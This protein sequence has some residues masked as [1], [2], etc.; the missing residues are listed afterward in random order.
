[1]IFMINPSTTAKVTINKLDTLLTA[2]YDANSKNIV[3]VVKKNAKGNPVSGVRI[4][5]TLDGVKYVTTDANGQTL[6]S[7][8]DFGW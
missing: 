7:T 8:K 1:M 6:Y 4:D 2:K 3:T 5:F